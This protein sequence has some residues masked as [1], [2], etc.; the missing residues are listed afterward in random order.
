MSW[1]FCTV[2]NLRELMNF[3]DA[4]KYMIEQGKKLDLKMREHEEKR[5]EAQNALQ[6]HWYKEMEMQGDK[7]AKEYRAEC[8]LHHGVPIA[9]ENEQFREIYDTVIKHHPYETKLKMMLDP[10]NLP[11]TSDFGVKD[12]TRFLEAVQQAFSERGYQLTTSEDL[13]WQA[14]GISR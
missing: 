1:D 2:S 9:R 6:F 3:Y 5:K 7:S 10:V 13:Y 14:M 8:K 11:V 4:A 12:M